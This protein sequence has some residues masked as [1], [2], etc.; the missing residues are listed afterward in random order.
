VINTQSCGGELGRAQR[1]MP[2][3]AFIHLFVHSSFSCPFFSASLAL[4]NPFVFQM[5]A[6]TLA[7]ITSG[8]TQG[9]NMALS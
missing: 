2:K 1:M 9:L 3:P 8:E 6:A 4:L 5:V 7:D